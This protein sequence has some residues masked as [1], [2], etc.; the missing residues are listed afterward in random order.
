MSD[1]FIVNSAI[2]D[3]HS[4]RVVPFTMDVQPKSI[5]PETD[6]GPDTDW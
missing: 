4:G 2:A 3:R 1:V 5:Y 6:C